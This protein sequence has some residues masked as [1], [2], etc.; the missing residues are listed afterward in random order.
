[1]KT[2]DGRL[3]EETESLVDRHFSSGARRH[4]RGHYRKDPA[5]SRA[6]VE[7]HLHSVIDVVASNPMGRWV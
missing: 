3:G 6:A 5:A 7:Q 1:M 2:A 4:L